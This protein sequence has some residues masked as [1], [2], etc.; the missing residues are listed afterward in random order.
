MP[1]KNIQVIKEKKSQYKSL[2]FGSSDLFKYNVSTLTV[3]PLTVPTLIPAE[4]QKEW[5][6]K[7]DDFFAIQEIDIPIVA[8]GYHYDM[9]FFNSFITG[10][11]KRPYPGSAGHAYGA[12]NDTTSLLVG[13]Q[14]INNG[15]GTGKAIFKNW[16]TPT[17]K[18]ESLKKEFKSGMINFSLVSRTR[19]QLQKDE[20]GNYEWHVVASEGAERNDAIDTG[21]GSMKQKTN[22]TDDNQDD[23]NN[24]I[25]DDANNINSGV[26][27]KYNND[28]RG[29]SMSESITDLKNK[30]FTDLQQFK[31]NSIS[32]QEVAR[33]W[34]AENLLITDLHINALNTIE[35]FKKLKINSIDDVKRL[36][37]ENKKLNEKNNSNFAAVREAKLNELF[38]MPELMIGTEKK[39]NELRLYAS[40]KLNS[41]D[42]SKFNEA[43]ED[44]KKSPLAL[45]LASLQA[46]STSKL[47]QIGIKD[48]SGNANVKP[49]VI[50]ENGIK[51]K[52]VK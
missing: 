30:L 37:E 1:T 35:E 17:P 10:L 36:L 23:D 13:G 24:A 7:D 18:G 43:I 2:D 9:E 6:I 51:V 34:G 3:N 48:N 20:N 8:N 15:D 22:E 39:P 19:D 38:G 12:R 42:E 4:I 44:F 46:D 21:S 33:A 32:F 14:Y 27:G 40:E 52:E 25:E 11:N 29:N 50:P 16:F 49:V 41:V 31:Q 28:K 45:S 5:G 47:N 26:T